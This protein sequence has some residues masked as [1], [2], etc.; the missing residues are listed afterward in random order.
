MPA[1]KTPALA[2]FGLIL[3]AMFFIPFVP[4]LGVIFGALALRKIVRSNGAIGGRRIAIAAI[5]VGIVTGV[6]FQGLLFA[7]TVPRYLDYEKTART[8]EA[9]TF[10]YAMRAA[11]SAYAEEHGDFPDGPNAWIPAE[12]CCRHDDGRCPI[13]PAEWAVSPWKELGYAPYEATRYQ[14]RYTK[15]PLADGARVVIEAKGDPTCSGKALYFTLTGEKHGDG[16]AEWS[17]PHEGQ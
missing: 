6:L 14:Y 5:V 1:A 7:I 17:L 15:D 4:L 10:L 8:S 13:N 11:L 12:P 9:Q 2:I 3:A 16:P